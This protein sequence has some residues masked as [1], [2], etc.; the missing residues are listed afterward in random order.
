MNPFLTVFGDRGSLGDEGG[1]PEEDSIIDEL[2]VFFK[3][4]TQGEACFLNVI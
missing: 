4:V 2:D 3:P 1:S